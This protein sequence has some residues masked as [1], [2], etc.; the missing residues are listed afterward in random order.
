MDDFALVDRLSSLANVEVPRAV[1]EI[2]NA[3]VIHRSECDADQMK[4]TVRKFLLE[5][6]SL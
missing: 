1:E 3:P 2:R 5:G 4:D 6:K